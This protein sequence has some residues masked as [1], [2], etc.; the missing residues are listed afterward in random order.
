MIILILFSNPKHITD[1]PV[2]VNLSS[3]E[4]NDDLKEISR[5][6]IQ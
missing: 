3:K 5:W 1:C 6:A 4:L 2:K